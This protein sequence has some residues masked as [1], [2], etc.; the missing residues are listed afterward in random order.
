MITHVCKI[1]YRS[2]MFKWQ[3]VKGF[4]ALYFSNGQLQFCLILDTH[5]SSPFKREYTF[6]SPTYICER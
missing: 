4:R 1:T 5:N 2:R 3:T 6:G